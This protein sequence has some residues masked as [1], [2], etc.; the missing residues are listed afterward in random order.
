M[1]LIGAEHPF[2]TRSAM[3]LQRLALERTKLV[4]DAEVFQEILHRYTAIRRTDAI[5]AAFDVLSGLVE[6]IFPIDFEVVNDAKGLALAYQGL[7][8]RDAIH[9]A[10]INRY[11]ISR[12]MSFDDGF[13][14][15]PGI[16][17]LS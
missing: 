12:L 1:Y 10:T 16:Q 9:L 3:L 2:K 8:A 5:Q 7:S 11:G 14:V 17:R 15:V 13:D 4:T 6:Q